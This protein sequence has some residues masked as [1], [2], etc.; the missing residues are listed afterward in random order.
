MPTKAEALAAFTEAQRER[1]RDIIRR[2]QSG[3]TIPLEETV[4]FL[5]DSGRTL[6]AQVREKDSPTKPTDVDFF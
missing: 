5:T 6:Q 4:A 3:E 1:A 2:I